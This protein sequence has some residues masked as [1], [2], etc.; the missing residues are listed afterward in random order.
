MVTVLIETNIE[1]SI[2]LTLKW[3]QA[4]GLRIIEQN[5]ATVQATKE[6]PASRRVLAAKNTWL[7]VKWDFEAT[8]DRKT[9]FVRM[10][11]R[12]VWYLS[13]LI[14]MPGLLTFVILYNSFSRIGSNSTLSDFAKLGL[15]VIIAWLALSLVFKSGRKIGFFMKAFIE[16]VEKSYDIK[17]LAP[18]DGSVGP[19]W[20]SLLFFGLYLTVFLRF[21][22]IWGRN[23]F[24]LALFM[25][26][27]FYLVFAIKR[28]CRSEPYVDWRIQIWKNVCKWTN[29]MA[30][31]V[32]LAVILALI[33]SVMVGIDNEYRPSSK[34]LAKWGKY[35]EVSPASAVMLESDGKRRLELWSRACFPDSENMSKELTLL[36][37]KLL[38][39]ISSASL[40][41][42]MVAFV[43]CVHKSRSVS[44]LKS[45]QHWRHEVGNQNWAG[46]LLI[47]PLP[48]AWKWKHR[49]ALLVTVVHYIFG[50]MLNILAGAFCV[51][52]LSYTLLG[53]TFFMAKSA[54]LWSWIFIFSKEILSD[55]LG[56]IVAWIMVIMF[57]LPF[58]LCL[59]KLIQRSGYCA[60][61]LVRILAN[62]IL[63]WRPKPENLLELHAF[64]VETCTRTG[65][66]RPIIL[67]TNIKE[68]R[69]KVRWLAI[70]NKSVLELSQNAF[71]ILD[72]E[73]LKAAIAHEL[74]HLKQGFFWV[75]VLKILSMLA[76]FPNYYLTVCINWAGR[77]M[78]ADRFALKITRNAQAL[79][80]A[81]IKISTAELWIRPGTE[82]SKP[83]EKIT[84]WKWVKP[85]REWAEDLVAAA[86]FFFG[87]GILGYTHPFL[88]ER[89]AAIS[90][91]EGMHM[92]TGPGAINRLER[93]Q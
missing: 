85:V 43:I 63:F 57:T 20:L 36:L 9:T 87:D 22:G 32:M 66:N 46:N 47:P 81:L 28:L 49:R 77:E 21:G 15:W 19:A 41:G 86:R 58:L 34:V 3:S 90:A 4:K 52:G 50:G 73:E 37:R 11:V 1:N 71:E 6:T 91:Y 78:E 51:E 5:R 53:R 65:I 48:Q 88:S 13:T 56:R 2:N 38:S 16:H 7:V 25:V 29:L 54:N 59:G 31:I 67:L 80:R 82:A 12:P 26:V 62:R 10:L 39:V 60:F 93:E 45:A 8:P 35:R 84:A 75:L 70:V 55:N 61:Y 30:S 79:H 64:T 18:I 74:G 42:L 92:A 89:L 27:P 23:G 17:Q 14:F 83:T 69:I 72:T 24:L 44:L 33:E 68:I 40:L 76:L